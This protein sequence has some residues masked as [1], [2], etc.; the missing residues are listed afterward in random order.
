[1]LPQAEV[2]SDESQVGSTV[3]KMRGGS[4]KQECWSFRGPFLFGADLF[5]LQR[6]RWRLRAAWGN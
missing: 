6:P 4:G 2:D 3:D 5:M 1:M